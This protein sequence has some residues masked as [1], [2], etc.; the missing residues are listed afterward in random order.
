M[1]NF[2]TAQPA[3]VSLRNRIAERTTP[4]VPWVGAGCSA[5][6]GLPT[7]N[8]LRKSL[9]D[10]LA[11]KGESLGEPDKTDFLNRV[12]GI[13]AESNPWLA[14]ER[15]KREAGQATYRESIREALRPTSS[16]SIPPI[17]SS[18]WK[19]RPRAVLTL[20]LDR[21]ATKACTLAGAEMPTELFSGLDGG[22]M[23]Q[24]HQ[25][26][27]P[28]I[29]NLHGVLDDASTWILTHSD[30]RALLANTGY[31]QFMRT[32]IS[33]NTIL[34]IGLSTDD[35]AVGGQLDALKHLGIADIGPH[36]WITSRR[37]NA[38]DDWAEA[39]GIRVIRYDD[40][41]GHDGPLDNLF[42][43]LLSFLP[44]D[45]ALPTPVFMGPIPSP[46]PTSGLSDF[47]DL[48]RRLNDEARRL[49][50]DST[51]DA[52]QSYARFLAD[53]D[54]EVYRAWYVSAK[55]PRNN[56]LGF[57]LLEEVAQGAFG[58]VFKA[59]T[60]DGAFVAVK[61]LREEHR[62]SDE[63][64]QAFRRGARSMRILSDHNLPGMVRIHS[65]SE[66][67]AFVAMEWID[68]P[69]LREVVEAGK[70][71]GWAD[72]LEVGRQLADVV[73]QAHRL[74]ERVLHRDL[75]PSNVMLRDF[76]HAP[77]PDVVVLDFDLS[78]HKGSL[79][80]SVVQTSG[81]GY[82]APEQL[83][84]RPTV[85][86]RHAAVDS[87]GLGM[88]LFYMI[89]R[90]H[91][92]AE[93][94]RHTDWP[95][96]IRAAVDRVGR[97][98]FAAV[99]RRF[100]RLILNATRDIQA[101]RWDLG[102]LLAELTQLSEAE[103]G[104]IRSAELIGEGL[105]AGS[106]TLASYEWNHD[107]AEAVVRSPNGLVLRLRGQERTG[108][109]EVEF[110]WATAGTDDRRRVGRW[111]PEALR[112]AEGIL[113]SGGWS[114]S[115]TASGSDLHLSASTSAHEILGHYARGRQLLEKARERLTFVQ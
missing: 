40:R 1:V 104:T 47:E 16:A 111:I 19:L 28:F 114:A 32:T 3:Y 2:D 90:K 11:R 85:S 57:T 98:R 36:Y 52:Y 113:K 55:P 82:L 35:M 46:S 97:P 13:A 10:T 91:P 27:R 62:T 31:T 53:H 96:S 110:N 58:R 86:T 87:F 14:F 56:L 75:R 30:L 109:I 49:L 29:A 76:W 103:S 83:E 17:H 101:Q 108:T 45:V 84:R 88:T 42:S 5:Q 26:P 37:D 23:M 80:A 69:S 64:L 106:E 59:V 38:T 4:I 18:L 22:R 24:V 51:G 100:A 73:N 15:L 112:D 9:F 92:I 107:S 105:L 21:L 94:H 12:A 66:I 41:D 50:V 54:E 43:D 39:R 25:T 44:K 65:A 20:N 99:P 48:R 78:W 60:E 89:G 61:L 34:F 102:Q 74:P 63:M 70:L 33:A 67:P 115:Y 71:S 77:A 8:Q 95:V 6:A 81:F 93:Q 79:E 72:V 7:W 68:G